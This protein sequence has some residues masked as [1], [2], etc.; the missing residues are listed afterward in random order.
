MKLTKLGHFKDLQAQEAHG[1]S[2]PSLLNVAV[3]AQKHAS[4]AFYDPSML[5]T[6]YFPDEHKYAIYTP[7]FGPLFV[8]LFVSVVRELKVW[9]RKRRTVQPSD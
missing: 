2:L 4:Y 3:S 7:L 5:A 9:R 1:A 8:P 6:L